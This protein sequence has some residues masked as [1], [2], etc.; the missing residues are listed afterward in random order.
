M[1]RG[2]FF[3]S[4]KKTKSE[5]YCKILFIMIEVRRGT[6]GLLICSLLSTGVTSENRMVSAQRRRHFSCGIIQPDAITSRNQIVVANNERAGFAT[7]FRGQKV[8]AKSKRAGFATTF[9]EKKW[10]Q[11]AKKPDLPPHSEVKKWWQK[12]KEPDLPPLPFQDLNQ[13]EMFL[14]SAAVKDKICFWIM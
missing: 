3:S 13:Q 7:T 9:S 2:S 14:S 4:T 10:W 1:F 6:G 11:K 12:A 5:E 8:V